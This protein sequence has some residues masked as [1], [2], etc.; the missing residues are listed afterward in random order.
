M[1]VIEYFFKNENKGLYAYT[2]DRKTA[3]RFEENR[4]LDRFDIIEREI[5][6]DFDVDLYNEINRFQELTQYTLYDK[7]QRP[8]DIICPIHELMYCES[9]ITQWRNKIPEI[10]DR[11]ISKYYLYMKTST[12]T[13]L[14]NLR[15]QLEYIDTEDCIIY[16][17]TIKIFKDYF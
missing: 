10:I 15:N 2:F 9:L 8:I 3:K 14:L 6:S 11:V 7:H 4:L 5:G 13:G 17:N 1:K 16:F 12:I